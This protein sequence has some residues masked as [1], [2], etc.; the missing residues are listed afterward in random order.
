MDL[1]K[2]KLVEQSDQVSHTI[3]GWVCEWDY[4]KKD[5]IGKQMTRAADSIS[6]NLSEA[7]GRYSFADRKRFAYYAR[8]S[9]CETILWVRKSIQRSLIN[10][11][12][13]EAVLEELESISYRLNYYI[14][15]LK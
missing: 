12:E 13:G 2:F 5:T 11:E 3:W 14:N 15:R 9:L 4:F 6:A 8:G 1:S 7:Y 10:K